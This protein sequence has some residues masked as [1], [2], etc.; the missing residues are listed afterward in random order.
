MIVTNSKSPEV[1]K[2]R[3][4]P[5]NFKDVYLSMYTKN[6][7]IPTATY[8]FGIQLS[9][10][11]SGIVVRPNGRKPE[12]KNQDGGLKTSNTYFSAC[13]QGSKDIITA[14][15]MFSGSGNMT[16]LMRRLLAE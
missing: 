7:E 1:E 10:K 9:N 12:W 15:L 6:N 4:W 2:P 13:T 3:W 14:L 11:H 16:R 8:V 5:Q